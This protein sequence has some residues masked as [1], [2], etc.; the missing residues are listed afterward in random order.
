MFLEE[1]TNGI[2]FHEEITSVN[3]ATFTLFPDKHH[4]TE[5]IKKAKAEIRRNRDVVSM[6]IADAYDRDELYKSE[7]FQHPATKPLRWYEIEQDKEILRRERNRGTT[8]DEFVKNIV[9]PNVEKTRQKYFD[10][11]GEASCKEM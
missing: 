8:P 6:G 5:D 3:G 9:L 1:T 4:T 10:R 11:Y 7:I 2:K